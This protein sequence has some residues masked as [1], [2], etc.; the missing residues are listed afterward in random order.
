[1]SSSSSTPLAKRLQM[2][3]DAQHLVLNA[4]EGY[5]ALLDERPSEAVLR[6]SSAPSPEGGFV[7]VQ[8]FVR[9]MEELHA[10]VPAAKL[11]LAY[12]GLFWLC[13]PKKSSGVESDLSRDTIWEAMKQHN[14]APVRQVSVDMTWSALRFRPSEKM[15]R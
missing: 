14:L 8:L 1:M 10:A 3:P 11:V 4:P 15:G 6:Q 9:S 12:D 2:L 13:Y 7:W 5:P